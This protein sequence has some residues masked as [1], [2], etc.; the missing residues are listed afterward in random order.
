M[1]DQR[2]LLRDGDTLL[3]LLTVFKGVS[4]CVELI[5]DDFDGDLVFFMLVII[6]QRSDDLFVGSL[7]LI[8]L[9][10]YLRLF[11]EKLHCLPGSS[12]LDLTVLL[13]ESWDIV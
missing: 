4:N 2:F 6:D 9:M 1:R 10:I 7:V 12:H 5:I 8:R 13:I 3:G 11:I